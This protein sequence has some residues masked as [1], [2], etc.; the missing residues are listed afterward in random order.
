MKQAEIALMLDGLIRAD[1]RT[2]EEVAKLAGVAP[3]TLR[4]FVHK[5][6]NIR[7]DRL[8]RLLAVY[9]RELDVATLN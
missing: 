1:T 3:G 6:R 5:G 8:I 9:R 4:Q 2:F 7:I